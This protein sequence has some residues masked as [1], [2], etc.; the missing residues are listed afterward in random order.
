MNVNH[1]DI[2]FKN[3]FI[4]VLDLDKIDNKEKEEP[5]FK[6]EP[7]LIIFLLVKKIIQT[8]ILYNKDTDSEAKYFARQR[9]LIKL[10]SNNIFNKFKND[11]DVSFGDNIVT[12]NEV[13]IVESY[14]P[15]DKLFKLRNLKNNLNYYLNL[16]KIDYQVL[17]TQNLKFDIATYD[18]KT[19]NKISNLQKNLYKR[20]SQLREKL[21]KITSLS[22]SSSESES[23]YSS[24]WEI[25]EYESDSESFTYEMIESPSETEEV[26]NMILVILHI[27]PLLKI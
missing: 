10:K 22:F 17:T 2:D 24:D 27:I 1:S 11:L 23:D 8:T 12:K 9:S 14:N 19:L 20:R 26:I 3:L 16:H 25:E 5:K 7:L 18:K 4:K 6:K 21:Q 15:Y 13:Y